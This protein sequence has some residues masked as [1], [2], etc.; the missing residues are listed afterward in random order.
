MGQ[1][2]TQVCL[3]HKNH[4]RSYVY[5]NENCIELSIFHKQ[6]QKMKRTVKDFNNIELDEIMKTIYLTI[7]EWQSIPDKHKTIVDFD[8]IALIDNKLTLVRIIK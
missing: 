3:D 1:S 7:E 4:D 5:I 2:K 8:R 6:S